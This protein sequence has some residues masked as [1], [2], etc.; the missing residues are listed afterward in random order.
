MRHA[1]RGS[2][3]YASWIIKIGKSALA[4]IR[5]RFL[6]KKRLILGTRGVII[7]SYMWFCVLFFW[8]VNQIISLK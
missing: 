2:P 5:S 8:I 1:M 7:T 4:D 6:Q 3:Q